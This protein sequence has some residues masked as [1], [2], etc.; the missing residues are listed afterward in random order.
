MAR[1]TGQKNNGSLLNKKLALLLVAGGRL[2]V[3]KVSGRAQEG[4]DLRTLLAIFPAASVVISVGVVWA[5][6]LRN[7]SDPTMS[8][9]LKGYPWFFRSQAEALIAGR[10]WVPNDSLGDECYVVDG[11]CFGYYGLTPSILRLPMLAITSGDSSPLMAGLGYLLNVAAALAIL[12]QVWRKAHQLGLAREGWQ[13]WSLYGTL[14][15][16]LGPGS[17]TIL[18]T[19]PDVGNEAILWGSGFI[20]AQLAFVFL[21]R[22]THRSL[23]LFGMVLAG[24]LAALS[25]PP[26]LVSAAAIS[27]VVLLIAFRDD[28]PWPTRVMA[29]SG[30]FLPVAGAIGVLPQVPGT[31]PRHGEK[32]VHLHEP[33]LGR[34]S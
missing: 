7:L 33:L 26:M 16:L 22:T 34:D 9:D 5:R 19:Y 8:E 1:S 3:V 27:L 20:L 18:V 30:L 32:C 6:E 13:G 25:R 24:L 29:V 15:L 2:M 31:A 21:W 23:A 4:R 17:I 12:A 14:C 11:R 10:F 28:R